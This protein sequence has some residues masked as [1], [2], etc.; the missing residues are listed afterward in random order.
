MQD[1]NVSVVLPRGSKP[2]LGMVER[3]FP[4]DPSTGIDTEAF[5]A[6]PPI[7]TSAR[8]PPHLVQSVLPSSPFSICGSSEATS[9]MFPSTPLQILFYNS[10]T[11]KFV[12]H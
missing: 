1:P 7:Q 5:S 2:G 11:V 12:L 4:P 6:W 10:Y 8:L 3:T 9:L